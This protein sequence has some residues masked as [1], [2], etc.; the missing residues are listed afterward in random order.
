MAQ[1]GSA[2]TV[3][4]CNGTDL[5]LLVCYPCLLLKSEKNGYQKGEDVHSFNVSSF[6]VPQVSCSKERGVTNMQGDQN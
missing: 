3:K 4:P 2:V 6:P 1:M 5:F